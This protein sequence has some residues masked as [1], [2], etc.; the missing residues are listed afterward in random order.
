MRTLT[1]N[2][3]KPNL[4]RGGYASMVVEAKDSLKLHLHLDRADR[5]RFP[6][7]P[8]EISFDPASVL[9]VD[10]ARRPPDI[11]LRVVSLNPS[12]SSEVFDDVVLVRHLLHPAEL[13]GQCR[14]YHRLQ[15]PGVRPSVDS[16]QRFSP[17]LD[18]QSHVRI[19]VALE[20]SF[21]LSQL[22]ARLIRV[23]GV[24]Q[25]PENPNPTC[26]WSHHQCHSTV[27]RLPRKLDGHERSVVE[28]VP[29]DRQF[30]RIPYQRTPAQTSDVHSLAPRSICLPP[31]LGSVRA[32][33]ETISGDG[34]LTDRPGGGA[35]RSG[36]H[37]VSCATVPVLSPSL[38]RVGS[39][40]E[41][42]SVE[43]P[44]PRSVPGK[45]RT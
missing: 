20:D 32:E 7:C 37:Y 29:S 35:G 5:F 45:K 31:I 3:P 34:E 30:A 38:M 19:D 40:S 26:V 27:L 4:I 6:R 15:V 23:F 13:R 14:P 2:G 10:L 44:V 17:S 22:L 43:T 42:L 36:R 16:R 41:P 18:P 21:P 8:T 25:C 39:G 11:P 33:F 1:A 28:P 12:Q 24:H 9:R